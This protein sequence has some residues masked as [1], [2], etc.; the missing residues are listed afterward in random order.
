LLHQLGQAC[1]SSSRSGQRGTPANDIRLAGE[2]NVKKV[3]VL[4]SM[5]ALSFRHSKQQKNQKEKKRK[6]KSRFFS[7]NR[8]T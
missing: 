4:Y 1:P 5:P 7:D 2:T 8:A 6:R 3:N